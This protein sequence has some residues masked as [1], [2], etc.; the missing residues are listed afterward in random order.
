RYFSFRGFN[1]PATLEELRANNDLELYD[2]GND[3]DETVN[4]AHDFERNRD[5]IAMM[6]G[7]LN[8]LIERE[9]GTD[10]GRFMHLDR[11]IDWKDA[12]PTAINL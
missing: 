7:K 6:N 9:I 5:L 11:W 3:P 1:T 2:L 12:K 4:L 8:T 10:D